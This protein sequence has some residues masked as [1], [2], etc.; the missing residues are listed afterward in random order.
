MSETKV[1]QNCK[2]SFTIEPEDF[3]FYE[4]M[5]VP[6]PT[7]CPECRMIRR[8]LFRN[9]KILFRR[10]ESLS[11]KD[12]F[13]TFPPEVGF[14]VYER[15]YWWS[16]NWDPLDYGR[17][18]D[19]SRPFFEQLKDLHQK[20]PHKA[21]NYANVVNSDYSA[22]FGNAKNCYLCFNLDFAEDS[23]YLVGAYHSKNCFDVTASFEG[24]LNYDSIVANNCF[25]AFF[26]FACESCRNVW[27]SRNCTGCSDCFGCT[28]LR[29]KQYYIFNQPYTKE[30]YFEKLKEFNLSS[31]SSLEKMKEAVEKIWMAAPYK[32]MLGWQNMNVTGNWIANSKNVKDSFAILEGE[33]LR[34][35]QDI[36]SP[37]AKDCYDYTIWGDHA[38]QL[39]EVLET[40]WNA[41]QVKF[42]ADCW[43]AVEEIEYSYSCHS[44]SYLFGCV[45]LR[46]KKYCILNKQYSKEEY[47]AL[48]ERII[49]H[50]NEMPY[51]DSRGHSYKYGEFFPPEF[52]QLAYNETVAQDFFPLTKEQAIAKGYLWRDTKA[53]EYQTK[54]EANNLPDHIQDVEDNILKEV[55]KCSSC[56]KAYRIIQMELDFLRQMSLPL[57]R[58]CVDCRFNSRIKHRNSPRFYKRHCQCAGLGSEN[59]AY[60]NQSSHFHRDS[61][62]PSEFQTSYAPDRP[63]IIYCEQCYNSEIV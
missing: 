53:Q 33:D 40:G 34:F 45:G 1:C 12:I 63:E 6:P 59:G 21:R 2:S 30:A 15:D 41:R 44:S 20:V 50:M 11:G 17:E 60:Q 16:D 31:Y 13:S 49:Q 56:G 32:F 27:F 55:I 51:K 5:K 38:E 36:I 23:A 25:Q 8:F 3:S 39:Y 43:P 37:Y 57:P 22:N 42:S 54:I 29:A 19:F 62:C 61:A 58:I 35:C 52:S 14:D 4:K 26:S 46:S 24:E 48:R 47:F 9:E 18:Y 7:W 10:K 28:N